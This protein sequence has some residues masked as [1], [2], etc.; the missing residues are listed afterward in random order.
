MNRME[1]L[2]VGPISFAWYGDGSGIAIRPLAYS[3]R[4]GFKCDRWALDVWRLRIRLEL[5]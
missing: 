5:N 2:R 3:A 1:L 4:P